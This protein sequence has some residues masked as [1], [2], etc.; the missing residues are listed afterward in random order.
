MNQIKHLHVDKKII[1]LKS[2]K[3]RQALETDTTNLITESTKI[4]HNG[5][6][7]ILYYEFD[8]ELADMYW[9]LS[10]LKYNKTVRTAGLSTFS[11]TFGYLP[12]LTLKRDFCTN[13]AMATQ[14]PKQHKIV[15][16]FGQ[17]LAKLY[18]TEFPEVYENHLKLTSENVLNQYIIPGT[19][20]TSGI[21]N[22]TTA[23]HYHFD[24]GNIQGV[25][26]NMV[27]LKNGIRGGHLSCPEFNI[28]FELKSGSVIFFDGQKILHG[29]T[30]IQKIHPHGYRYSAV[31]YSLKGMWNCLPIA[32]EV[33]RIRDRK[34]AR[35][36]KRAT[37]PV[38]E[39]E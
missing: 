22:K 23:L 4:F 13:S 20:F 36:I 14:N 33:N 28:K 27:V 17:H 37:K 12:R 21:I 7:I 3:R 18:K 10:T 25:F 32:E 34:L 35:E 15:M 39:Q 8:E 38:S 31:Y 26:S 9:A 2:F 6:P 11:R 16:D 29:V 1:D 24:A 5:K 30:P 19:P